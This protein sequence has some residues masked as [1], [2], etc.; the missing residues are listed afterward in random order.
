VFLIVTG[1]V[2]KLFHTTDHA[3]R[4]LADG[5]ID[6]TGSFAFRDGAVNECY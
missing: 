1:M 2:T 3:A 6:G 5:F 4:I